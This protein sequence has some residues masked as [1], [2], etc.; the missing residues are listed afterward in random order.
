MLDEFEKIAFGKGLIDK[1]KP[2]APKALKVIGGTL[3]HDAVMGKPKPSAA[4][5]VSP[6]AKEQRTPETPTERD[7]SFLED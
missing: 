3:L 1:V 7:L 6:K 5:L 4:A 2:Y